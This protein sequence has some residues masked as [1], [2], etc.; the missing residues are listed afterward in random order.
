[1]T[2]ITKRYCDRP[3]CG[4]EIAVPVKPATVYIRVPPLADLGTVTW[5]LCEPCMT[6]LREARIDADF[7]FGDRLRPT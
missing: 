1:M 6:E 3:G 4:K 7:A 5:D 2:T